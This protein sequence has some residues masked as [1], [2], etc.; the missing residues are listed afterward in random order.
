MKRSVV[1]KLGAG[2]LALVLLCGCATFGKGPSDEELIAATMAKW[3]AGLAAKDA[4]KVMA[5]YS[6]NFATPDLPDKAAMRELIDMAI[7][8]GYLDDAEVNT[9]E[10]KTVIEGNKATV[11][12]VEL[13]GAMGSMM[14]DFTLQ[15]EGGAWLI[16]GSEGG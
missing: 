3:A 6:E 16:V 4:D 11:G 12:P 15:K 7:D 14:L 9:D 5:T 10:A 13:S 1:T 8:Q 2:V